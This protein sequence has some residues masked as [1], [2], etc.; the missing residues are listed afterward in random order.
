[1]WWYK[2]IS[3]VGAGLVEWSH[4][5]GG[6]AWWCQF[7]QRGSRECIAKRIFEVSHWCQTVITKT[8]ER[9][10]GCIY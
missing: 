10:V 6:E 3:S 2:G 9:D 7:Q 8:E 4:L 1:M 5:C